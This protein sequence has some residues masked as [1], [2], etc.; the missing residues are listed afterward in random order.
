MFG[1]WKYDQ[2]PYLLGAEITGFRENGRI[3]A[4]GYEGFTFNPVK[5]LNYSEG[6][7]VKK[8]L[9]LLEVQYHAK[10]DEIHEV[11]NNKLKEIF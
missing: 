2:Y 1:F 7:K 8:E 9:D 4:K 10:L 5:I 11:F 6:V 3:T